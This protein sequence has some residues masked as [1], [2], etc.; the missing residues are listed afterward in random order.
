MP[1]QQH[2]G[3]HAVARTRAPQ[4]ERRLLAVVVHEHA[5]T[6]VER[7]LRHGVEQPEGRHHRARRQH[8]D[9][10][11]AA[12]HVVDLLGEVERVLVE[13]VLLRPRALPAHRDRPLR[14]GDHR[15][16]ERRGA[17][18]RQRRPFRNLRRGALGD[19]LVTAHGRVSSCSVEGWSVGHRSA[20]APAVRKS[21][22][23][24]LGSVVGPAPAP[25]QC[26][27]VADWFK[28]T[29][30]R[31]GASA[32]LGRPGAHRAGDCRSRPHHQPERRRRAGVGQQASRTAS[33][34]DGPRAR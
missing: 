17:G 34:R 9:L 6:A 25:P 28:R 4:R 30:R 26:R 31:R 18:R 5:V 10:E 21:A 24:P 3:V 14:L 20:V 12:G 22:A 32:S 7:A 27:R 19:W 2:V 33:T 23:G 29:W 15:E 13:D 16:A 1:G 11:V 8:L